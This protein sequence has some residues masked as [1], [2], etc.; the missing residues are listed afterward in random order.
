MVFR[1]ALQRMR[2]KKEAEKSLLKQ[3]MLQDRIANTVEE[4]KK[5]ANLRELERLM[6]EKQEEEIKEHLTVMRKR[7]QDDI[8][9]NHN[10]LDAPNITGT[11]DFEVLKQKN[12][13]KNNG[14]VLKVKNIFKAE[15]RPKTHNLFFLGR[16]NINGK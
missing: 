6:K 5:S 14:E 2:E 4:R 3:A 11:S 1:E 7:R 8:D 9:F 10:P 13:V 12:V 16:G 15:N